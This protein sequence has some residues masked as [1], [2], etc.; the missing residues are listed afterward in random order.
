MK[1]KDIVPG[2]SYIGRGNSRTTRT[3]LSV[4]SADDCCVPREHQKFL[5]LNQNFVQYRTPDGTVSWETLTSFAQWATSVDAGWPRSCDYFEVEVLESGIAVSV[6]GALSP[7]LAEKLARWLRDAARDKR[8][9]ASEELD[10][11]PYDDVDDV[12]EEF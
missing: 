3:V 11:D 4:G 1:H 10:L 8:H 6:E 2:E 5:K 12:D 9:Y 7:D